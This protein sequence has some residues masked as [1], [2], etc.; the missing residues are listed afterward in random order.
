[1]DTK[2]IN[3]S[4][5]LIMTLFFLQPMAIGSW[6]ALIPYVKESIGLTKSELAIA[7]LGAPI[8]LLIALQFAGRAVGLIGVRR[9]FLLAFPLQLVTALFPIMATSQ[10]TLF[11]GLAAFG[12]AIAF[13]E[14]ALNVYAGRVEKHA[15]RLIMNRCHGFWALGLTAGSIVAAAGA[16]WLTPLGIMAAISID[17]AVAGIL[18]SRQLPKVGAEE[19]QK[20]PP[21]RRLSQLPLALFAIGGFMFLIT[22]V[23]G[24]MADWA[25]IY[26]AERTG[27]DVLEA[28]IAVTVFSAFMAASRFLGDWI[29][30]RLGALLHARLSVGLAITGL[31]LLAIPLP[32]FTSY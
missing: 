2:T 16:G 28:G 18:A 1:M 4:V 8:A 19:E 13:M 17:S 7:L 24:A 26:L 15:S 9:I 12:F 21:R 5:I 30:R 23:E 6:L 3:R 10:L 29:K 27:V 20:A 22:L 31:L 32:V 11:L 14:V 25:A